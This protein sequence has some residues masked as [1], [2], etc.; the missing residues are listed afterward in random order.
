[1]ADIHILKGENISNTNVNYIR[2][3]VKNDSFLWIINIYFILSYI[4]IF[5]SEL[6]YAKYGLPLLVMYFLVQNKKYQFN[7]GI[8]LAKKY[9]KYFLMLYI[10]IFITYLLFQGI[11]ANNISFR[12]LANCLFVL[13]PIF[14][15]YLLVPLINEYRIDYY[16]K[17]ICFLT[18]GG[19]VL[20]QR[21]S[22]VEAIVNW[23]QI[24]LAIEDSAVSSESNLYPFLL[25]LLLL[26][27]IY[28]KIGWKYSVLIFIFVVLGF[29]RIALASLIVSLVFYK[30][31][32]LYFKIRKS[33]VF[34]SAF[35]SLFAIAIILL[36]Y[37][38]AE[39]DFDDY[40]LDNF[41]IYTNAFMQG[42]QNLYALVIK[43]I[44]EDKM[45]FGAGIGS[46]D[47]ILIA[48]RNEIS[49]I[50]NL[51]SE[52]LRWFLELGLVGYGLW[53]FMFF[54]SVVYSRFIFIMF[55]FMFILLLT[56]N[57]MIYFD[58]MM[59]Y[60]I[61]SVFSILKD[62]KFNNYESFSRL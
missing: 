4:S 56:D 15:V 52:L 14:T 58:Y 51:H 9:V 5:V 3:S 10:Y 41:N 27:S 34:Y 40:L 7:Y 18:I 29:K 55:V 22:L 2:Y 53:L 49:N 43:E 39:G 36:Y 57:V 20:E 33:I 19:Y 21:E 54:K 24:L 11:I 45:F 31:P 26:Y 28:F 62:R 50:T 16:F 1:M 37:N 32:F 46:V 47:D 13:L 61:L 25:S 17:Y 59:Y 48:Y 23:K 30:M 42:R 8:G 35:F 38:I 44:G 60:Y 12:S 6:R